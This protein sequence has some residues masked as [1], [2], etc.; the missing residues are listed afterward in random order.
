LSLVSISPSYFLS[1]EKEKIITKEFE[2]TEKS[3]K[4]IADDKAF[5]SDIKNTQEMIS[6]L[7]PSDKYISI[8]DLISKII[9]KK[10]PGLRI[11]GITIT[12]SKNNQ[13]QVLLKGNAT[14]RD[15]LKTF[16]ENLRNGGLF[17]S[18]DLPISNFTKI[19]DI[20][21]NISLKTAI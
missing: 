7:K 11:D 8:G 19:A 17:E 15:I 21:F 12:S 16:A 20:D 18:V 2:E 6:L 3:G 9:S 10:N 4:L 14:S 1:V 5:Q 13:Y